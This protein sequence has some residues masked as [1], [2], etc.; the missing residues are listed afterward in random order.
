MDLADQADQAGQVDQ[1]DQGEDQG[2]QKEVSFLDPHFL[3]LLEVLFLEAQGAFQE[4][5]NSLL[6]LGDL[7]V[8]PDPEVQKQEAVSSL[9]LEVQKD[10]KLDSVGPLVAVLSILRELVVSIPFCP[11]YIILA[12][13]T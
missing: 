4:A 5:V 8:K 6:V 1:E 9:S 13:I 12:H 7:V 10:R 11:D 2:D 3:A